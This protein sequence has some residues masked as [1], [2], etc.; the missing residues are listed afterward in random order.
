MIFKFLYF[1]LTLFPV[2]IHCFRRLLKINLKV[3]EVINCLN[4]NTKTHCFISSEGS[5]DIEIWSVD[6]V[7]NK[8][9]FYGKKNS[10]R[11]H[12]NLVNHPKQLMY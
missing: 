9:H 7:L 10:H 1:P 4:K 12:F 2:V 5:Y 6:R 3:Y 11:P 8:G